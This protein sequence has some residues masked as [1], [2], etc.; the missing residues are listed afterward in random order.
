[1]LIGYTN[2][3]TLIAV[4]PSPGVRVTVADSLNLD[5]VRVNAWCYI[6]G[7][8]LNES[9]TKTMIVSRSRTMHPQPPPL[10]IDGTV[11]KESVDLDILG[12]TFDSKLTFEK[13]LRS[14]SR[15]VPQRIGILKSWRVF[16]DRL[17]LLGFCFASFGIL[18]CSVVFGCRYTP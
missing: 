11:L 16:Q 3:S 15:A 14:V 2:A 17:M 18:L 12:M 9:N 1:M 7:M 4:V 5:L 6:W 13:H 8:K 10:T